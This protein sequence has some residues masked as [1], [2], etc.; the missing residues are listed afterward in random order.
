MILPKVNRPDSRASSKITHPKQT[1]SL[2]IRTFGTA[3]RITLTPS[4]ISAQVCRIFPDLA[5]FR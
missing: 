5:T 3:Q 1:S 4:S 2:A